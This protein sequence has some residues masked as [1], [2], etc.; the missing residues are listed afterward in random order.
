MCKKNCMMHL[1]KW[2][3]IY[4]IQTLY[5][6]EMIEEVGAIGLGLKQLSPYEIT[7]RVLKTEVEDIY[8]IK[9]T[10]MAA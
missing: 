1:C 7:T 6:K 4:I 9:M 5:W 3:S 2:A 10:N 8:M